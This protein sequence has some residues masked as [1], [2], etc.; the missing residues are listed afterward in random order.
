MN[1]LHLGIIGCG[2][3]TEILHLSAAS[4][5]PEVNITYVA[6]LSA[7]R[8]QELAEAFGITNWSTDWRE[9]IGNVD[10]VLVATPPHTHAGLSMEA[11]Q[12]GMDVLCEKPLATSMSDVNRM[13]AVAKETGRHLSVGHA[14][15][16]FWNT[17]LVKK[18]LDE[19]FFGDVVEV[20]IEEGGR[21][22]WPAHTSSIFDRET[23]VG[24]LLANGVHDIDLLSW[25]FGENIAVKSYE[26]DS[27][28]G[29]E[30][31]CRAEF[32]LPYRGGLANS[33]VEF[34]TTRLLKNRI[35]IRATKLTVEIDPIYDGDAMV[36]S[37]GVETALF[38]EEKIVISRKG[39]GDNSS[40]LR[41]HAEQLRRFAVSCKTGETEDVSANEAVRSLN[42]IE[43]C[44]SQ[45]RLL[46]HPWINYSGR[47]LGVREYENMEV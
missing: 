26:D 11:M 22:S 18:Y 28:N 15:R 16:W 9:M 37:A 23:A 12:A 21:Y 44:Y 34:S 46:K 13:I 35:L 14:R 43:K 25:W 8:A 38:G 33:V 30:A 10:A 32:G 29:P 40:M 24:V 41:A 20:H 7:A 5:V 45:R 2:A 47:R 39:S 6:D 36:I 31:N 42:L 4:L 1:R 19:G 3:A 17:R 27:W